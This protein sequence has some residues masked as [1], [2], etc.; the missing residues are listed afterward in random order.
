MA[1]VA[2]GIVAYSTKA[3]PGWPGTSEASENPGN[4]WNSDA[5]ILSV[6]AS[7]SPWTKSVLCGGAS[8]SIRARLAAGSAVSPAAPT[9]SSSSLSTKSPRLRFFISRRCA[10]FSSSV[11][12]ALAAASDFVCA[13]ATRIG[14]S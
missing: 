6:A 9:P 4:C 3:M 11:P 8:S 7:G 14:L 13:Y 10:R 2:C 5:T 12:S 1:A